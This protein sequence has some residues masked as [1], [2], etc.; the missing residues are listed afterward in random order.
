GL[1]RSVQLESGRT[2]RLV[3]AGE[4]ADPRLLARYLTD[5]SPALPTELRFLG[6]EPARRR[7]VPAHPRPLP[8]T[9]DPH[10]T[11][12]VSGGLGALGSVA[13][14]WLLDGGARDVVVPTRAPRPV[15][16]LLDG[17]EDRIVVVRCDTADRSD[18]EHALRDIRECGSTIRGV[19]HA[20]GALEDALI[21]DVTTA[22]L[23]RMF[24]PKLAAATNLIELT[25]ADPTD[26]VLL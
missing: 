25:A 20:A 16:R 14:R 15:P 17:L 23:D 2:V 18:L 26:F 12:V 1:L 6:G 24:A 11:Y 8:T 19:V 5:T 9:I 3:W 22:Q 10:G 13:V 4:A 7:F 21:E